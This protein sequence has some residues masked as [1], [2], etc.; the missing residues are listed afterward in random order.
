MSA[1]TADPAI[2]QWRQTLVDRPAIA[3]G[4]VLVVLYVI[5]GLVAEGC[6][7]PTA[8]ARPCCSPARWPSWPPA[9]RCAVLTGGIDLSTVM[10]ANFAAYV[11]A[12]QS[13]QGPLVALGLAHAGRPGRRA[14]ERDR[15]RGLQGQPADHDP[16]HGQRAARGRHRRPGRRRVP[17]RVDPAPAG[18]HRRRLEHPVRPPPQEP[19][20]LGGGGRRADLRPVPDRA[21]PHHLRGGGQPR[22]L[23][24]RRGPDLAGPAGRLRDVGPA[25]RPR[26]AAVLRHQLRRPRPDQRLPAAVGGGRG[27]RRHLHPRRGRRL[28]RH[29]P[30]RPDP[31]RPEPAAA[32]PG[33]DRGVRGSS[34]G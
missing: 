29:H 15:G 12:N 10:T 21:R 25:G 14:G 8:S 1:A 26:R 16:R 19:A 31:D 32:D 6:S 2:T 24:P 33:H 30:R 23:P 4:G 5:T 20:R 27:H 9:R 22:R 18:R 28:H 13:G 17:V 34:T 3:L 7:A 11:A